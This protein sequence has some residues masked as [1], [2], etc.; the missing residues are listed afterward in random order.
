MY[1]IK[2]ISSCFFL[3]LC[4]L[5]HSTV[6]Y[7][8]R[9]TPI[10][11]D[12]IPGYANLS[13]CAEIPLSL[14]VRN[15]WKGCADGSRLTSYSCFCT[16]SYSKFTFDISTSV[17]ENCQETAPAAATGMATS[18][19][20]VFHTYCASGS[21][22]I[23]P[24]DASAVAAMTQTSASSVVTSPPTT[25]MPAMGPSKTGVTSGAT[26]V[27]DKTHRLIIILSWGLLVALL[28]Y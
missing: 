22:Y 14:I 16:D 26:T 19:V 10:Y 2:V 13:A 7:D 21:Q 18:A 23:R 6:G 12:L 8:A 15:M 3:V 25:P 20:N 9:P 28:C 5:P 11:I 1:L 24:K 27:G 17:V 4:L